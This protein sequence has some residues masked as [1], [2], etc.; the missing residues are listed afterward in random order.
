MPFLFYSFQTVKIFYF[1]HSMSVH[2]K[3]LRR[4]GGKATYRP[5]ADL[6]QSPRAVTSSTISRATAAMTAALTASVSAESFM[7]TVM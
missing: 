4:H 1:S 7:K 2:A 5:Q 3:Q 6:H